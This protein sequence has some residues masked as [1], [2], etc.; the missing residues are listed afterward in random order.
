MIK[1]FR[2]KLY[3]RLMAMTTVLCLIVTSFD[4]YGVETGD[5]IENASEKYEEPYERC[6]LIDA[7]EANPELLKLKASEQAEPEEKVVEPIAYFNNVPL[8]KDLQIYIIRL[9][10]SYNIDPALVMAI[11]YRES[12][13]QA[14][15]IG[16]H[17]NSFGLMQ[18]QPKWHQWRMDEL[19]CDNLLDPYQNVAVGLH[20]LNELYSRGKST[21]WVLMAYNGGPSC[22]NKMEAKGELSGYAERALTD[23]ERYKTER[24]VIDG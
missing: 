19:G 21:E 6:E 10:E 24:T 7:T 12:R 1:I 4:A 11:I 13:F 5:V 2:K 14:D 3:K 17:G 9:C 22:A 15:V 23:Y 20:L 16:D 18:I 8:E